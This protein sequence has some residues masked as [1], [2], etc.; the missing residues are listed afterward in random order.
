ME[1]VKSAGGYEIGKVSV[2][3]GL[4]QV[5]GNF[6]RVSGRKGISD[7]F[8]TVV[9][10]GIGQDCQLGKGSYKV[11]VKKVTGQVCQ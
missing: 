7:G 3:E 8:K 4:G 9:G 11:T 1:I 2:E 10:K 6:C 5:G